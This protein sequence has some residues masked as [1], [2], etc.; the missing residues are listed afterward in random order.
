MTKQL[1]WHPK[2]EG[3]NWDSLLH[4][5]AIVIWEFV[6]AE[7][8]CEP[9]KDFSGWLTINEKGNIVLFS[10]ENN[11]VWSTNS[12]KQALAPLVQLL[13]NGNLVLR[14]EEDE[15]TTN[16]LWESFD[17]P[18]NTLLPRMK[19]G[20]D[21][22][23][24]LNRHLSS[25][26][27]YGDFTY[28]IE[29]DEEHHTYPQLAVRNGSRIL[30]RQG[31]LD[32]LTSSSI[33]SSLSDEFVYNDDEVYY[34][35]TLLNK[36]MMPAIVLDL[37]GSIEYL[38]IWAFF[39]NRDKCDSYGFCGPNSQCINVTEREEPICQCLKGFKPKNEDNWNSS[40]GQKGVRDTALQ[41]AMMK[42]KKDLIII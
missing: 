29:V 2:K 7:K 8:V 30:Y 36:S 39:E 28:G 42:R 3:F 19:L 27:C 6:W 10:G 20:W 4:H 16:Y 21:L 5:Q 25:G 32:G 31:L 14:D 12:S 26:P 34:T 41:A 22:K 15:I 37:R 35:Y 18:I 13:D 17:Y 11:N 33:E 9:I 23:T 1:Y 24:G 40:L 38:G